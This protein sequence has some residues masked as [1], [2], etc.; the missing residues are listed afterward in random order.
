MSDIAKPVKAAAPPWSGKQARAMDGAT[1]LRRVVGTC[2][3][4]IQPNA[5]AIALGSE[6]PEHV[7]QLRVGLRRLRSGVRGLDAFA[8]GLPPAWEDAVRPVFDALGESRDRHVLST[9][10]V[11]KLREAGADIADTVHSSKRDVAIGRQVRRADFQ[12]VLR[13]LAA[14]ADGPGPD[15]GG[16]AGEG[17]AQL[18]SSLSKLSRQVRRGARHFEEL[19]FERRHDVRKRLKRL[20]YLAEFAAPAFERADVKAWLK[21]VS[22]AQDALGR[23]VDLVLA[24][25]HFAA[26]SRS[27]ARFAVGWLRAKSGRSARD[28][29]RA[30]ARL[31]DAK[32]FW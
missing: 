10:L 9:T 14:F 17:L 27:D 20:R 21:K 32:P 26:A 23:H 29:R 3:A 16:E 6:D 30:L 25:R 12:R 4:Q 8:L 28:A 31:R 18:V 19:A 15:A 1:M 24:E 13:E 22:P 7:H 11:P 2:L 5:D